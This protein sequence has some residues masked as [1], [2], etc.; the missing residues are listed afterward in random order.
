MRPFLPNERIASP[1][2]IRSQIV[3]AV[4]L[5]ERDPAGAARI[6]QAKGNTKLAE[7]IEKGA[8]DFLVTSSTFDQ[9][10]YVDDFANF[11]GMSAFRVIA[12]RAA[13][14]NFDNEGSSVSYTNNILQPTTFY[15]VEQGKPIPTR[16]GAFTAT[17][18]NVRK[19][20][21]IYV[22]TRTLLNSS[23]AE[24][25]LRRGL[26][27]SIPAGID[28]VM[29]DTAA[30]DNARPAGLRNGISADTSGGASSMLADLT[31]LA[32]KVASVAGN[33]AN[34]IFLAHPAIAIKIAISL[35]HFPF[36]VVPTNGL[37]TGTIVCVAA[38]AIAIAAGPE[39][40]F[41]TSATTALH[42]EDSTPADIG[43]AGAP[44]TSAA[45]VRSMFQ[46][47]AV[48]IKM[49]ASLDYKL[50]VANS[51]AWMTSLAWT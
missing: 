46:T 21:A 22:A 47:D 28:A 17:V 43:T 44:S 42:M 16:Q 6:A 26:E 36:Q 8:V 23:N 40:R 45:P 41:E 38:N 39:I 20:A 51:L 10:N 12:A 48:A 30:A 13:V 7:M 25:L 4:V 31:L 27:E 32:G 18:L 49:V 33:Y 14:A 34:I 24:A 50:R 37:G 2:A 9:P 11:V 5:R 1:D 35:P 15:F 3:K 29:F 19:A